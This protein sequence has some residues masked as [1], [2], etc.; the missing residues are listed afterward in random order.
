MNIE[1]SKIQKVLMAVAILL[2]SGLA[3]YYFLIL[4]P[5]SEEIADKEAERDFEEELL[6]SLQ[7][8]APQDREY[9]EH[10]IQA[11]L[12]QLPVSPW[13]DHWILDMEKAELISNSQ[14]TRFEFSKG[15]LTEE[16]F[17]LPEDPEETGE[18]Q[19]EENNEETGEAA[20]NEESAETETEGEPDPAQESG[21]VSGRPGTDINIEEINHI[22]ADLTIEAGTYEELFEFLD[23][24]E[25]LERYTEINTL[26]FTSPSEAVLLMDEENDEPEIL[27]FNVHLST[28]YSEALEHAFSDY[29]PS[30]S[31]EEPENKDTPV[32]R[33][34]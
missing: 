5:L 2:L 19:D 3:A 31:F 24:I 7:E 32:Y 10:E 21:D 28:Y 20:F 6:M 33:H 13:L 9:E 26:S 15:L 17:R 12:R 34:R 25:Q 22:N 8:T 11:M 27:T 18:M 1:Y 14:I 29:E 4:K 30:A 16:A 23:E